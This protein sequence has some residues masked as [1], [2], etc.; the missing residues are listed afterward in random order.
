MNASDFSFLFLVQG[1]NALSSKDTVEF[2]ACGSLCGIEPK[3]TQQP[4]VAIFTR[5]IYT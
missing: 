4:K 1:K 2:F 3:W 5:S